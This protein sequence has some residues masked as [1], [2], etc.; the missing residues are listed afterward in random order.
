[1]SFVFDKPLLA[2]EYTFTIFLVNQMAGI[3]FIPVII[4]IAYGNSFLA[5][6]F[7]HIGIF[8]MIL[9]FAVRLWKGTVAALSG[10]GTTLFYLFL[11]LCTL[12][13]L[14]LLIGL[15]LFWKL[16]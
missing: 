1:M 4:F 7:I 9:A 12:E 11:Y 2:N 16:A 6:A 15:K 8:L 10:S 13:I 14:P 5:H 3:A